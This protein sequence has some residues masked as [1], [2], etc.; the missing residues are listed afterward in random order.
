MVASTSHSLIPRSRR[1]NRPPCTYSPPNVNHNFGSA[2]EI[3]AAKARSL[4]ASD[5]KKFSDG[6]ARVLPKTP[7]HQ[8][9]F[10]VLVSFA[11]NV[12]RPLADQLRI[13]CLNS[14]SIMSDPEI[15]ERKD[16]FLER[17]DGVGR[18]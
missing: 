16:A 7:L 12:G 10:D 15:V 18:G 1:K 6:I 17:R 11:F 9:E 8:Y 4:L 13:E 14:Y 3:T 5:V 2:L